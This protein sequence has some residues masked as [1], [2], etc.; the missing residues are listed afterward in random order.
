MVKCELCPI[1]EEC[2]EE[3][4]KAVKVETGEKKRYCPLV[5]AMLLIKKFSLFTISE[6][7]MTQ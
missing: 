6:K 5:F 2:K 3:N 4:F 7:A 1:Q